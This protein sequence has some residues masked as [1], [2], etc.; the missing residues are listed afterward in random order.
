MH[1]STILKLL[2]NYFL[3]TTFYY[4]IGTNILLPAETSAEDNWLT[5]TIS[6]TTEAI[7]FLGATM[8]AI[9]QMLSP[10]VTTTWTYLLLAFVLAESELLLALEI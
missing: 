7:E 8:A 1:L 9:D 2:I 10:G 6:A 5:S 4:W 3:K